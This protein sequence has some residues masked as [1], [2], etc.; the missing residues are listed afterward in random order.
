MKKLFTPALFALLL[1]FVSA[2][3]TPQPSVSQATADDIEEKLT[4]VT[5]LQGSQIKADKAG[6]AI[7][8]SGY[9]RTNKQKYLASSI[10]RSFTNGGRV[11][12]NIQVY[13]R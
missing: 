12:N 9:A 11:I 6:N 7:V 10:A 1:I 8:L 2:G 3:C 13:N 4:T 5:T